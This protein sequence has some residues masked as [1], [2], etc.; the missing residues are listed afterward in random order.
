MKN[1]YT[2]LA[3]V[4][5]TA[6][7][8]AQ[9]PEKMS[10]QAVVRDSGGNL[11]TNQAVG[12]QISI[13]QTTATGTAVYVETQTATTNVNGLVT[14]E[15]GTGTI[16]SG[17]FTTIDWSASSYF[18]KTETDPSGGSNYTITGTSQ[19]LSVPYALHAKTVE[20]GIPTGGLEGQVLTISSSGTPVWADPYAGTIFYEDADSD[21]YGDINSTYVAFSAPNGYVSN[22]TDCNDTDA[23]INPDTIWYLD[24]D[25]DSFAISTVTQCD[26]PGTGYTTTVKPVGDC[27]DGD[28]T[29]NPGVPEIAGDNIDNNCDNQIDEAEIGQ[30]IEGG[31]VFWVDPTDNTH[32]LVCAIENQSTGI[33]WYNGSYTTTGA[34]GTAIGTGITNTATIISAQ[35]AVETNYAAGLAKAY[36]G[37]G[38]NDW[39]L[40]S[41]DELNEMY[42]NEAAI[43]ASATANG[44]ANFSSYYFWSST[45][46]DA[47]LVWRQDFTNGNLGSGFKGNTLAVR[48]V[49]AF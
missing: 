37:G 5:L 22:N 33:Q 25:G 47:S 43:N 44:G 1:L 35:G 41:K 24:A 4:L 2:F 13:L 32:G 28:A 31:V 9:T 26:S 23:T 18:I 27:N 45:E 42:L 10:Y 12:I 19:L 15:I 36:T 40:P 16:V 8:F 3:A 20:N 6:T 30:F 39:F 49:R 38:F 17:G 11:L 7:T 34:T 14:I 29:I 21:G 48:A 46:V